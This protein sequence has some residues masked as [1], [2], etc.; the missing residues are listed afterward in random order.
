MS[1]AEP[2]L[3][4]CHL[5][6]KTDTGQ[7]D[8]Q[9]TAAVFCQSPQD[10]EAKLRAFV[11]AKGYQL[12]WAETLYP[13]GEWI[14]KH[15]TERPAAALARAVHET[16]PVEISTLTAIGH[17]I[18][19]NQNDSYLIVEE[20]K[21]VKPLDMQMGIHPKRTVPEPLQDPLFGQPDPTEEEIKHYGSNNKVPP[22]KTYAILD[23]AKMP[24][25]LTSMLEGSDLKYQS[26]FQG[27]SQEE[28]K[29]VAPYLVELEEDNA[30]TR[31]LFTGPDGI[32]GLWEKELGIYI[33]SRASFDEIRKHF[34]KF[35]RIQ[36][37]NNKWFYFRFWEGSALHF[38]LN[39]LDPTGGAS[40]LHALFAHLV[41]SYVIIANECVASFKLKDVPE[42]QPAILTID[43]KDRE[44]FSQF[45]WGKYKRKLIRVLRS[46]HE[47]LYS[48]ANEAKILDVADHA[49]TLG[50]KSEISVYNFVRSYLFST[51]MQIDFEEAF[52]ASQGGSP[53][54]HAR[55]LWHA[56]NQQEK[57]SANN[58]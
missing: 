7:E 24:N 33:R 51:K 36:D 34:R 35:T 41:H 40:K 17:A 42:A 47:E 11:A 18:E 23:A 56:L 32:N 21:D 14:A 57:E 49:R 9:A 5:T 48:T 55:R 52:I 29:E 20:I 31:K 1:T 53:T 13:A 8:Y 30:F 3:G 6:R 16:N 12:L 46:E 4:R 28:L 2:W 39:N 25:L 44:I 26:L 54:E 22:L 37:E 50:F 10:Y 45:V 19:E 38:Y 27:K 58:V 43:D 15:P